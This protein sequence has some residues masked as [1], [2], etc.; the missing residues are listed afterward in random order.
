MKILVCITPSQNETIESKEGINV[1]TDK[2]CLVLRSKDDK[3]LL[4][5]MFSTWLYWKSLDPV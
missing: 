2:N 3:G 4:L 1:S 5:A